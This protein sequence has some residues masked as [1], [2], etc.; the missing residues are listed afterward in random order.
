VDE[1]NHFS[2]AVD[3]WQALEV[4]W[5]ELPPPVGDE[6][7]LPRD[8]HGAARGLVHPRGST[9]WT[10]RRAWLRL[11]P[12][13]PASAYDVTLQLAAPEP[14]PETPSVEVR[15]LNGPAA[16]FTLERGFRPYVLR[17]PAAAAR[18]LQ[19][20][21]RAPVWL[22]PGLMAELGVA[23]AGMTVTPVRG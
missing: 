17:V 8:E 7:V 12:A 15:V 13:T 10:G 20:E 3:A 11:E 1:A 5:R 16:R 19:V 21:I 4:A 6:V 2:Y 18:P 9:R 23:I 14:A 22:K